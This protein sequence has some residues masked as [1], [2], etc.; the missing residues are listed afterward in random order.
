MAV[1]A[2]VRD[3]FFDEIYRQIQAGQDIVVVTAD[4]G[5]PSLD[6]LRKNYPQRYI[7][8]GIA[9]QSL[10]SIGAGL[11]L[12][13]Q[14]VVA[15]GL[16][17]FPATRA[18][19]Q[20]RCLMAELKIPLTV[21]ALNAGLCSAECG[22][23]HIPVDDMAALRTL[24]NLHIHNPS[25]GTLAQI[26]AR[27]VVQ[28]PLPRYIRFDKTIRGQLYGP[29]EIDLN[30]GFQVYGQAG[31]L[32]IVTFGCYVAPLRE[33]VRRWTD[34][35]KPVL[36]ADLHTLPADADKLAAVLRGS[37]AILTVEENVLAGGIGSYILELMA[38]KKIDR[39]IERLGLRVE[40]GWYSVFTD[41][42]YIQKQQ[43]LDMQSVVRTAEHMLEEL[44]PVSK[45]GHA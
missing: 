18:F 34:A 29:E 42:N 32:C 9:E 25:D 19:D 39:P 36:L 40:N 26:L 24:P 35:G 17:P 13:G 44:S 5:A 30:S 37:A 6:A 4:L 28:E 22:Y 27:M 16:N 11:A 21:C 15:Y 2:S 1:A 14:R 7:S 33:Q 23:T 12:A 10:I 3:M 20:I 31:G 45:G 38:D 43:A 8:I 41:R